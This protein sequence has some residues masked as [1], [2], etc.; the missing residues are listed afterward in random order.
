[1]YT[2]QADGNH[3]GTPVGGGGAGAV[4][5]RDPTTIECDGYIEI[6]SRCLA[7]TCRQV[8]TYGEKPTLEH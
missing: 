5:G 4:A 6:G 2:M 3:V 7:H 1:M 8:K